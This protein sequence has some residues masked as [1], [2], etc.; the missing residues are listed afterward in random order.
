MKNKS[1]QESFCWQ[2]LLAWVP[3]G[4]FGLFLM[5]F[6][7]H[8]V[9][10]LKQ[11]SALLDSVYNVKIWVKTL[12]FLVTNLWLFVFSAI[13]VLPLAIFVSF[14]LYFFFENG[15]SRIVSLGTQKIVKRYLLSIFDFSA[16]QPEVLGFFL[17]FSTLHIWLNVYKSTILLFGFCLIL[18]IF[19]LIVKIL[20]K[21]LHSFEKK[22]INLLSEFNNHANSMQCLIFKIL[23]LLATSIAELLVKIFL[24]INSLGLIFFCF[25]DVLRSKNFVNAKS[26]ADQGQS[27][28]MHLYYL[29]GKGGEF[30]YENIFPCVCLL[31]LLNFLLYGLRLILYSKKN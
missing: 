11:N 5:I 3:I 19:P 28:L 9:L 29:L 23:P 4:L 27:L 30:S 18:I 2:D 16:M 10:F 20:L 21:V 15:E 25:A 13:S 12:P 24:F 31:I 17:M 14:Y 1:N 26:F 8:N 22:N 7:G 6:I